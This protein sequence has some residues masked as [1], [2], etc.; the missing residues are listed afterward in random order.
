MNLDVSNYCLPSS[1]ASNV[2]KGNAFLNFFARYFEPW[3]NLSLLPIL[4]NLLI[5]T[6]SIALS[7]TPVAADLAAL[8]SI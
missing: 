1:R 2:A 7:M 8:S 6:L 5:A 3:I 4:L